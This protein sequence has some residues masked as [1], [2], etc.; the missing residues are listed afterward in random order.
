MARGTVFPSILPGAAMVHG[1]QIAPNNVKVCV[2]D[3]VSDY[4]TTPLPVPC[5]EH[6]LVGD[7]NGSF[8]QWPKNLILLG[9]DPIIPEKTK[10]HHKQ[11]KVLSKESATHTQ[12]HDGLVTGDAKMK[13]LSED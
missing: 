6:K 4:K 2:D 13:N 9:Q 10:V 7:A 5:S 8:I 11:K 12:R 1:E 3:V